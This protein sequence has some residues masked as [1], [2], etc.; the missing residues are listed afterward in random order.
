MGPNTIGSLC[1]ATGFIT[2]PYLLGYREL[3][4]GGIAYVSQS[5]IVA[6]QCQPLEDRAYPISK[7]CDIANK[8]D[9]NEVDILNYLADDADTKVVAMHMED[10]KDGPGFLEAARRVTARK[11]LMIFRPA[12]SE[13]GARASASHTG[14]L[15][16]N[17]DVYDCAIRQVGALRISTWQEFWEVP[18]VFASGRLASGSRMA[19]IAYSGG[20]GVVAT[21]AAVQAGLK[22]AE[23][24]PQTLDKLRSFDRRAARNPVDLG[25]V[26][27]AAEN[28]AAVQEEA[29]RAVVFDE[30][31]D[32]VSIATYVGV[33]APT[34]YVRDL[35]ER[36]VGDS[37]KPIAIW[38]YGTQLSVIQ[39]MCKHL[40][41]RG[42]PTFTELETA[43]KALGMLSEYS[44]YRASL[45]AA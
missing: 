23:F 26:L 20:A 33:L 13:E 8:C 4:R 5:G 19:I 25:P 38:I 36:L 35:F 3:L 16:G 1:T 11:P 6:A 42:M 18:K 21:D 30:N 15:A 45:E 43:V 7:M 27:S 28:P 22:L 24:T 14:S 12:R 2:T 34:E 44:R 31:V 29:I 41:V 10:V 37:S 40:D 17:D 32:C 9:V 39:E